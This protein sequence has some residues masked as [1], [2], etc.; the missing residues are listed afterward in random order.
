M[1]R[2][3]VFFLKYIFYQSLIFFIY[4]DIRRKRVQN[5]FILQLLDNFYLSS[6]LVLFLHNFFVH[7]YN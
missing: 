2:E 5:I 6:I 3:I 1:Y 7:Y 4:V